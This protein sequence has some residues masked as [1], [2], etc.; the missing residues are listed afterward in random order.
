M[1]NAALKGEDA[2]DC[3]E[4]GC[5]LHQYKSADVKTCLEAD[6][7]VV[8]VGDSITR[9]LF[10][11]FMHIADPSLPLGPASTERKHS[12]HSYT[13]AGEVQFDYIW[14]PFLNSSSTK[15]LLSKRHRSK[16]TPF[17]LVLGSGLW[18]LR[19]HT[20]SGGTTAWKE[21]IET[22]I[23]DTR[24]SN[25]VADHLVL[26]PVEILVQ[27]KLSDDRAASMKESDIEA[28]NAI[29]RHWVKLLPSTRVPGKEASNRSTTQL[30]VPF[31]FNSM[32]RASQTEDGLHYANSV[33]DNQ[34]NV[35]LNRL[36]N[37]ALPKT[38]PMDKSCCRAYPHMKVMQT[39]IVIVVFAAGP[40]SLLLRWYQGHLSSTTQISPTEKYISLNL[41]I[42]GFSVTLMYLADRTHLF[43]K[44][45]KQFDTFPFI[46]LTICI[47]LVGLV[48]VKRSEKSLGFLNR[49]QTEEW[50]G[51]MQRKQ[52]MPFP[53]NEAGLLKFFV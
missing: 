23:R 10:F 52:Q 35:L 50:K 17:L 8:F 53:T 24:G 49:D 45:Q 34:A 51:W 15:N 27:S 21:K 16:D 41:T 18:Y 19:Y 48:T 36:C 33:L 14:D 42:F 3:L 26:L 1:Y 30:S 31:V 22:I 7:R 37:D 40:L 25:T 13:G 46:S 20:S 29:M 5:M 39:F 6:R 4:T 2:S 28:M 32:L 43:L 9:S 38:S 44:E 12:D 11:S 47:F